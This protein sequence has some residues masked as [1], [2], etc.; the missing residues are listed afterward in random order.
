MEKCEVPGFNQGWGTL[1][2]LKIISL[3]LQLIKR[4]KWRDG[5]KFYK[6]WLQSI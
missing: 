4:T 3:F 6:A 5:F 2:E 1:D